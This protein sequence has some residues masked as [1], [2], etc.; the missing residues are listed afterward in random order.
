MN[1]RFIVFEGGEGSGKSTV[2]AAV[3]DRLRADGLD[4][5]HTREPGGTT[6]GEAVRG[7]LHLQLAPWAEAF[8]FLVA[9]AQV[10]AEVIRPALERGTAVICDRY[11]ASFLAYQG[12]GRGLDVDSLR[13]ANEIATGGLRPGL[14][15]FLDLD[16]AVGLAR[17]RGEAESIRIGL[18]TLEFHN[19]VRQ[20]Y[21]SLM[22]GAPPG[23]WVTLDAAESV[24]KVVE[25]ASSAVRAALGR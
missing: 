11:E 18:E 10:V 16:P 25:A 23:S 3:V 14:T 20:G 12:Y 9:R 8:A 2:A 6:A 19:R 24:G 5:V 1:E 15:V 22:A 17:K 4:V 21:L 13:T 7:L